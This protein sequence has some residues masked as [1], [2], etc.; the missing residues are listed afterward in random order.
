[1]AFCACCLRTNCILVDYP[2]QDRVVK[3]CLRCRKN[4]GVYRAA[5]AHENDSCLP[6]LPGDGWS[7]D[8]NRWVSRPGVDRCR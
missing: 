1:M 6:M 4:G 3:L 8:G 2:W 7:Y 5:S